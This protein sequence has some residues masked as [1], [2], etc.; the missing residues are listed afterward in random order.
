[1][2]RDYVGQ[3]CTPP[4]TGTTITLGSV[5][6]GRRAFSASGAFGNGDLVFCYLSDGSQWEASIC[7]LA[8]G[9]PDVLTGRAVVTNSAGNTSRLNFTGTCYVYNDLPAANA[10]Y[11]DANG[12][13]PGG[14]AVG[15]SGVG[16]AALTPGD[17]SHPG[18]VG[19]FDAGNV[20]KG[21]VGY[22]DG[23]SKLLLGVDA[24]FVGW[25]VTGSLDVQGPLVCA[26]GGSF[27][28]S[29]TNP[30]WRKNPSGELEQ[31]GQAST[32]S[33]G[34]VTIGF[35]IA[36]PTQCRGITLGA[37]S[38]VGA[39]AN[40]V[41]APNVNSFNLIGVDFN[42]TPVAGRVDWIARGN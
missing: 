9:A 23:I 1:M 40:I 18:Y 34:T 42:G 5:L 28:A 4:G 36:F 30:G 20:R 29:L 38:A 17:A 14:V 6:T 37:Y 15:S 12:F 22:S 19:F 16:K 25:V 33:G 3:N 31:F 27:A 11:R 41:G 2:L 24:P 7:T 10:V 13:V 21:F 32:S 26:P 8:T 35:P 39:I